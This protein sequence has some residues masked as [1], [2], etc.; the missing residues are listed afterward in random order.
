MA[1]NGGL[2]GICGRRVPRK[3]GLDRVLDEIWRAIEELDEGELFLCLVLDEV[4]SVFLDKHYDPSDFFYRFIR[5]ENYLPDRIHL[6]LIVISNDLLTVEMNLDARVV[7]SMGSEAITFSPYSLEELEMIIENRMEEAFKEDVFDNLD[8]HVL[9]SFLEREYGDA[10]K[11]IDFLRI[12]GETANRKKSQIDL[13]V[14]RE[15]YGKLDYEQSLGILKNLRASQVNILALM[16]YLSREKDYITTGELYQIVGKN[17]LVD[18]SKKTFTLSE[19]SILNLVKYF[20]SLGIITTWNVSK[21]R[22]GY[23]KVI[24]MNKDPVSILKAIE[25]RYGLKIEKR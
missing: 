25:T 6:C 5:H 9:T 12:C 15:A 10:R 24:R 1:A 7:S 8:S 14:C 21:G 4:E 19:R 17:I 20:E 2:A 3:V 23:G 22:K 11:A 16:A 18:F 13:E